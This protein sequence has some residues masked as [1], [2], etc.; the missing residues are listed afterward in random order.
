MKYFT[1]ILYSLLFFSSTVY[2]QNWDYLWLFGFENYTSHPDWGGTVIDFSTIPPA[3]YYADNDIN[4][5]DTNASI[6]DESGNLLFYTNG[7]VIGNSV[8]DTMQNGGGLN[9]GELADL[10][11]EYGY[12]LPQGAFILPHPGDSSRYFLV[13]ADYIYPTYNL[14][15]VLI[16]PGHTKHLYYSE[17]DMSL[18]GGLGAVIKKNEIIRTDSFSTGQLSC[19][20][21]A[22]GRDWWMMMHEVGSKY[23]FRYL[24]SPNGITEIGR[25][26]TAFDIKKVGYGQ[27]AYSPDG[28]VYAKVGTHDYD[29]PPVIDIYRVD[30]CEGKLNDHRQVLLG[31]LDVVTMGLAISP[32]SRYLY[33]ATHVKVFQYDL[34]AANISSSK[35]LI[36][37]F[38]GFYDTSPLFAATFFYAQLAPDGKIYIC[39]N[40]GTHY[41]HVIHQPNLAYPN[42]NFKNHDFTLPYWNGLSIPNFPNYRLGPLDG[43]PCDTLGLDNHPM[44]KFRYEQD[45]NDYLTINFTDLSYYEPTSWSWDFGDNT[46]SNDPNP[47][48]EF[49]SDG[50][51]EVCLTVSNQYSSNTFCRTLIIGTG[52]SATQEAAI[53]DIVSVFPNPAQSAT[54]FRIG[55]DYLPRQAM[56]TLYTATGQP[57]LTQRLM[58]GWSVVQLESMSPGIYFWEVKDSE[59]VL[60]TGKLVRQ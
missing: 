50:T 41:L 59:R 7:Q 46:S 60:G 25:D 44:A 48:H 17:I 16:F 13:H 36:A 2:S 34:E 39:T 8:Y 31:E 49:P 32:N 3:V 45:E 53:L 37:E 14:I 40:N 11:E 24:I 28:T 4:M 51:Y 47:I 58:A 23:Y 29:Q 38:D 19:V 20:R 22:N 27:S 43:S 26:S 6:C 21:H 9:P 10:A 12:W 1:C 18:N 30:R 33:V 35:K 42:C 5:F 52:I 56:L 57:I 15:N 55:E 54:N